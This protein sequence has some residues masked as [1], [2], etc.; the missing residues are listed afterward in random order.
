MSKDHD[1]MPFSR[2]GRYRIK[3]VLG[4]GAM[5]TIYLGQDAC[6]R[7]RV[8]IK[9]LSLGLNFQGKD[10]KLAKVHFFREA[11]NAQCLDHPHIVRIHAMGEENDLAYI[12]M[13]YLPGHNLERYTKEIGGNSLLPFPLVL[14]IIAQVAAALDHAHENHIVH[15]DIKP[16]N[17]M[18]DPK[19][20]NIKVTDF[21]IA[22]S[23]VERDTE[24]P[25]LKSKRAQW[26]AGTPYYMSPEQIMGCVVDGRSDLFSL[27][28][29]L[30]QLLTGQL[31]F[32]A[33]EM[34]KLLTQISHKP[35]KNP[36]TVQPT[37]PA[38]L[39][40]V[41]DKALQKCPATRYQTGAMMVRG[42]ILCKD[43]VKKQAEHELSRMGDPWQRSGLNPPVQR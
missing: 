3:R 12:A 22:Q 10:S 7:E 4:K 9:T 20:E 42:L 11:K 41:M 6:T 30:Y 28:V 36:C 37:L 24:K 32:P 2:I 31:P 26:V 19:T 27:G 15:R 35:H 40:K 43:Q 8:A 5:G 25:L 17:M 21:G 18:F 39:G 33:R 23:I 13:E 14:Q 29:V 34:G 1:I 16:A 38:C